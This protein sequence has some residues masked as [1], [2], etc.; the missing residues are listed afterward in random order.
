MRRLFL[1]LCIA[2]AGLPVAA[3]TS[4]DRQRIIQVTGVGEARREPDYANLGYSVRGE[5]ATAVEAMAAATKTR[6]AIEAGLKGM[7]DAPRLEFR[8]T[9]LSVQEV[10]G[11][12][13]TGATPYAPP[14]A[15]LSTGDC[16][17]AGVIASL[18]VQARVWP[19]SKFGDA[20]SMATQKGAR[21][22]GY[23]GGGLESDDALAAAASQAAVDEAK[24]QAALLAK[25]TGVT[26]GPILRVTDASPPVFSPGVD[27]TGGAF[28]VP[29]PPPPPPPPAYEAL[30]VPLEFKPQP[31]IK[32]AR[33]TVVFAIE[34]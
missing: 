17:V 2:G 20:A 32:T 13:C 23:R 27:M 8:N 33:V 9:Q 10:R 11:R 26:L 18:E 29:P 30:S 24:T 7:R 19:A 25:S 3:Q 28:G 22:V 16:A 21:N 5:A 31:I 12:G 34:P 14:G 6:Q 15:V 4:A 1:A